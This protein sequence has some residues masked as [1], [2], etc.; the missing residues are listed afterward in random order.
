[1]LTFPNAKINIGL[2]IVEKRSDGYHNLE[3]LFY[4]VRGLRDCLEIGSAHE[5][6]FI[7]TGLHIDAPAEKN[8]CVTAWKLLHEQYG[9]A[10]VRIHLHKIIPFGA[11][12]GGGSADAAFVLTA[13]NEYFDLQLSVETVEVLALQLGSD[14][15]FFVRN[16]PQ[17]VQ[18]RG[19]IFTP[20]TI[21]LSGYYIVLV[22]PGIHVSTAQAYAGVK[23]LKRAKTLFEEFD[24]NP[25]HWRGVVENDFEPSVC[26]QF[27]AIAE[28]KTAMYA[29]GALYAAMSGS[30]S[31]VYG[32]FEEKPQV[33]FKNI[34]WEG[35]L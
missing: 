8:L 19:E 33:Q 7:N 20:A 30:G 17:F 10:P 25:Q 3:S 28:L 6:Q 9:I 31:T 35:G 21:D 29:A 14:C 5:L 32:I 11:G 27:P 13:L 23:P 4:P 22:N 24:P 12:L 1:M 34:I 15:P 2:R 18:G 26:T 16:R